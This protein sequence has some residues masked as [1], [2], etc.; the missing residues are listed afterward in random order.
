MQ[1]EHQNETIAQLREEASQ[2]KGQLLRYEETSRREAQDWKEQYLRAEQERIRLAAR[3]DELVT[4]QLAVR[5]TP[6][7]LM[8]QL[9]RQDFS[10]TRIQTHKIHSML[11]ELNI[12]I[13]PTG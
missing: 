1:I 12:P 8:L 3:V 5:T 13:S 7:V 6:F 11:L 4:D 2:W 9:V 10:G